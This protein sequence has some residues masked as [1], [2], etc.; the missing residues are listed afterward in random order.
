MEQSSSY[1]RFM[2]TII[3]NSDGGSRGNPGPA[4]IGVVINVDGKIEKEISEYIGEATNNQAEYK[5]VIAAL[6]W[7]T[8]N[9][10][11]NITSEVIVVFKLD[12]QLVVEQLN[13]NY[14]IKNEGLKPLYWQI[15][16][17]I[18]KLGGN[19][20]FNHVPREQNAEAD[21]LVNKALD[22]QLKG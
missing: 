4:G 15:R 9:L 7:L 11:P 3:V 19:V 20:S 14:K 2:Q 13:G 1:N 17:L 12:S 5:A 21:K 18:I 22:N 10:T 6:E 8:A 16:D